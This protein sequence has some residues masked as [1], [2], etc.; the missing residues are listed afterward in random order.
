M[1]QVFFFLFLFSCLGAY[2]LSSTIGPNGAGC[3]PAATCKKLHIP[4]S[5]TLKKWSRAQTRCIYDQLESG[6]RQLDIRAL[7]DSTDWVLHHC[8]LGN[9][10]STVLSEVKTFMNKH[11]YEVLRIDF[12]H[13]HYSADGYKNE[14]LFDLIEGYIGDL[15]IDRNVSLHTLTFN[16]MWKTNKRIIATFDSSDG[17][18]SY[19]NIFNLSGIAEGYFSNKVKVSE[20]I[21]HNNTLLSKH[22]P[23]FMLDLSWTLTP[24]SG[25][26]VR[27]MFGC[28]GKKTLL[29]LASDADDYL[30]DWLNY[31]KNEMK[32]VVLMVDH[33]EKCPDLVNIAILVSQS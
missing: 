20:M 31:H 10:I 4:I 18:H 14:E 33:F 26:I 29:E 32:G 16:E 19:N 12:S 6:I 25:N 17:I 28:C 1:I 2:E 15:C 23:R 22:N 3:S 5:G 24:R 8:L 21:E 9:K 7:W 11:E 27:G 13:T 30:T